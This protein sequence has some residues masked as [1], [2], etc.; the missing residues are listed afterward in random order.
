MEARGRGTL[1]GGDTIWQAIGGHDHPE[2]TFISSFDEVH[3][4]E[5]RVSCGRKARSKQ[6]G[7][8]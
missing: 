3:F 4:R 7:G 5:K 2:C 8:D 6:P 1:S